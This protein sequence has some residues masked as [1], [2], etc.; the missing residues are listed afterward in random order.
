MGLKHH[1]LKKEPLPYIINNE[2][3]NKNNS[4]ITNNSINQE[5]LNNEII[6]ET[7]IKINFQTKKNILSLTA[8][9]GISTERIKEVILYS[10]NWNKGQG[11]IYK[12]LK[13]DWIFKDEKSN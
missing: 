7:K 2:L 10:E 3:E 9:K 6:D 1:P 8:L 11:C 13:F 12:A 5:K 4:K